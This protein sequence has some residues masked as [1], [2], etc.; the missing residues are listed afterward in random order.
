[1]DVRLSGAT[2]RPG[3]TSEAPSI[4]LTSLATIFRPA[5][6]TKVHHAAVTGYAALFPGGEVPRSYMRIL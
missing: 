6:W 4:A 3:Q 5:Q 2:V 1:M